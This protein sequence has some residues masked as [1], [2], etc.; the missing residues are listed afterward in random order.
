M[1]N[2]FEP[3]ILY[4]PDKGG[5]PSVKKDHGRSER[6][7]DYEEKFGH[8]AEK[9]I[10]SALAKR[11]TAIEKV[12][13]GTDY[14][15]YRQKVDFWLQLKNLREPL[16][17]QYTTNPTKYKE[18]KDFLRQRN[19]IAK[20]EKRPDSEIDWEGNANVV[21]ILGDHA[22]ML[23]YWKKIEQEGVRPEDV[24]SD[25]YV[26]D[27]FKN[28]LIELEEVNPAKRHIFIKSFKELA[29]DAEKNKR[30]GK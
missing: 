4:S 23:G 27:F 26:V 5:N 24:V 12:E 25:A 2:Q 9:I 16:G 22:K 13:K 11:I 17:I 18:K 3:K 20:K 14:E 28:V 7:P 8:L 19:W 29:K 6:Y 30:A 10:R 15:D 1:L 21:V